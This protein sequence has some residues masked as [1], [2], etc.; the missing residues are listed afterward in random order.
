MKTYVRVKVD[1]AADTLNIGIKHRSEPL[2]IG[3]EY[4][5]L[6]PRR[7]DLNRDTVR[8]SVDFTSPSA[9]V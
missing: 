2:S 7:L 5:Q 9:Y 6:P 8:P 1:V 4:P 3:T